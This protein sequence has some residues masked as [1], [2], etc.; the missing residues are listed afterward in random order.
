MQDIQSR[1]PGLWTH[2]YRVARTGI[3]STG[4]TPSSTR[5]QILT[6]SGTSGPRPVTRP[7]P[8]NG[9]NLNSQGITL[10]L[11]GDITYAATGDR[12]WYSGPVLYPD[13]RGGDLPPY[14]YSALYNRAIDKLTDKV[15]GDLDLSIDLAEYHQTTRMFRATEQLEHLAKTAMG[16][17]GP[18]KLASQLWLQYTYGVKPLLSDIWGAANEN[19]RVVI[20][21]SQ[22]FRARASESYKPAYASLSTI[23][24]PFNIDVL[25]G[26]CKRSVT[27]G[28]DLRTDQFDLS[29]WSSLNPVSIAWEIMP[30]SFVADWFLNVGGYLR[31]MET[32]LL[33]ANKFRGGYITKLAAWDLELQMVRPVSE[34]T[35]LWQGNYEGT[36]INRQVL[37]SYPAPA[38]PILGAN[39]GSSRLLSAAS[40][41]TNLLGGGRSP[42]LR[43]KHLSNE[44][45]ST[46]R[47]YN[48]AKTVTPSFP[49]GYW[50]F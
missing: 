2:N 11:S 43:D 19:I 48:A 9:Y 16:R 41:L 4:F 27:I 20:N 14:D 50:N 24:G 30:F 36:G 8:P 5:V 15:R 44:V 6:S 35:Q 18:L 28:I 49:K 10:M 38:L 29:R 40:L 12:E 31:N 21:K 1:S 17:F 47:G 45:Q 7:M 32:Y 26:S 23:F 3:T 42:L 33:N 13:V 39:L 22:R 34:G 37:T 46:V 25:S